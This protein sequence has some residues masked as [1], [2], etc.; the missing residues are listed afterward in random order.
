LIHPCATPGCDTLTF[1]EI[2]LGCMQRLARA[3]RA[4]E[5]ERDGASADDSAAAAAS[6]RH[7]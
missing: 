4:R 2:C 7:Q 1:G 3:Q 5:D 6:P